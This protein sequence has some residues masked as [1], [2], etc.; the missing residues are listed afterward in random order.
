MVMKY[1][2]DVFKTKVEDHE[3]WVVQSKQLKGCVAQGDTQ[4]EALALFE[5]IEQDWLESAAEEGIPIPE[6]EVEPLPEYSGKFTVRVSRRTHEEA[7]KMAKKDGVSLNQYV[8]DAIVSYNTRRS[9][10]SRMERMFRTVIVNATRD[11]EYGIGNLVTGNS[12]PLLY[13]FEN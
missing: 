5:E 8:N 13:K 10:D 7:A 2:F 9:M 6:V 3:F 1:A 4:E 11:M 12:G